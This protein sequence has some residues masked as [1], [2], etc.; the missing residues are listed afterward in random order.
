M[1]FVDL[2]LNPNNKGI[3]ET[4]NLQYCKVLIEPIRQVRQIDVNNAWNEAIQRNTV[5][6]RKSM[7]NV[8]ETIAAANA[9]NEMTYH[10]LHVAKINKQS[11]K[12][13]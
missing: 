2:E 6:V 10:V 3:Y 13:I 12:D 11:T 1:F 7:W 4:E 8:K 9:E 5:Y